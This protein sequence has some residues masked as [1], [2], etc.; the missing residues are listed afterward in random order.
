MFANSKECVMPLDTNQQ[1]MCDRQILTLA[2]AAQLIPHR[3]NAHTLW[4]WSKKGLRGVKLT[5][6]KAGRS[7]C[8][9]PALLLEF[10][11]A[12]GMPNSAT[13]TGHTFILERIES[14]NTLGDR[15]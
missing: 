8:T 15:D 6:F 11:H 7:R 9:T 1:L 13:T 10:L 12:S 14:E 5:T 2:Q 4:R 3:P